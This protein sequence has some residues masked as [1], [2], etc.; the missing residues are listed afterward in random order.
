MDW[1]L[2]KSRS[3]GKQI[4]EKLCVAVASGEFKP[5]DKLYS[6]REVAL[7]AG[8]NPNTVQKSFEGLARLG[9]I[10]SVPSSGWYVSENTA[11]AHKELEQ[12]KIQ[13]CSD[14]FESMARLGATENDALDYLMRYKERNDDK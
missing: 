7:M 5:G 13:S 9:I 11:S 1:T 8:V 6:V 10:S 3:I 12:L 4:C 2:N 14:F